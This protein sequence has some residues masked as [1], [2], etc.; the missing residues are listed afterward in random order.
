MLNERQLRDKLISSALIQIIEE[1]PF[2]YSML[3]KIPKFFRN[4]ISR[5]CALGIDQLTGRFSILFNANTFSQVQV[6]QVKIMLEHLLLHILFP[7]HHQDRVEHGHSFHLAC[8]MLINDCISDIKN[9]QNILS[10]KYSL[11]G[12]LLLPHVLDDIPGF[13]SINLDNSSA[14]EVWPIIN[15]EKYVKDLDSFDTIDETE[16]TIQNFMSVSRWKKLNPEN[17]KLLQTQVNRAVV[18]AVTD[19]AKLGKGPGLLPN[20]LAMR[21]NEILYESQVDY[22]TLLKKF[23]TQTIGHVHKRSWSRVHRKYPNQIRGR[24]KKIDHNPRLLIIMDTSQSMWQE[25]LLN[26]VMA[27]IKKLKEIVPDLWIVGGDVIEQFRVCLKDE[28]FSTQR[29]VLTGGGGT[30]IQFGFEAA[31]DLD[32]DGTIV[33]TDGFIPQFYTHNITTAFVIVPGGIEV[34]GYENIFLS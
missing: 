4:D 6:N 11:F 18:D 24:A 29:L 17:S 9:N 1:R 7:Q 20:F 21:I 19:L 10:K 31:K 8:D 34:P 3:K 32:V 25:P 16:F 13:N 26:K 30:D 22:S 28:E 23:T 5:P 2:Y 27:E 15:N 14:Y 12:N 33:L